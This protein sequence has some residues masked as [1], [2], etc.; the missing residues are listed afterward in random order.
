MADGSAT[1]SE[2]ELA[3]LFRATFPDGTDWAQ[4]VRDDA[5]WAAFTQPF[6]AVIAPDFIYEDSVMPDHAGE[7]YRGLDGLRRA[8]LGFVEPFVEMVYEL[9]RILGSGERFVSIHRVRA[10][11]RHTGIVQD[12]RVAYVWTYR[13]GMLVHLEGFRDAGDA[14]E[15]AGLEE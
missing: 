7:T 1:P 15:A 8:S 12:S 5:A 9:E 6:T 11:A 14:L 10:T 3:D 13:D 4:V 2:L